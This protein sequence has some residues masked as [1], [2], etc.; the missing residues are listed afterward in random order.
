MHQALNRLEL[1]T[2]LFT[3][4]LPIV[5]GGTFGFITPTFAILSLP[6]WT[7]PSSEGQFKPQEYHCN[8]VLI[9]GVLILRGK[10]WP[11]LVS[12]YIL[13]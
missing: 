8:R 11:A 13:T 1:I 6:Q 9:D 5:Q 4:R 10:H 7:C 2:L 3:C 12:I